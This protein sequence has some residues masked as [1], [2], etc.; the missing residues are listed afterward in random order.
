MGNKLIVKVDKSIVSNENLQIL[1]A[2]KSVD[3]M[4]LDEDTVKALSVAIT[5]NANLNKMRE[6]VEYACRDLSQVGPP[7]FGADVVFLAKDNQERLELI[8][9]LLN[10]FNN[11]ESIIKCLR[12][13]KNNCRDNYD[14]LISLLFTTQDLANAVLDHSDFKIK[15][16]EENNRYVNEIIAKRREQ[17]ELENKDTKL[18][19]GGE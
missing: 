14:Q 17:E 12:K 15:E 13:N 1:Q 4:E 8:F 5:S 6:Q 10:S 2:V 18:L 11:F 19:E 3:I 16:L 9:K 7:S